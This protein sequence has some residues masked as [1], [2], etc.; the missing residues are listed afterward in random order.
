M[1]IPTKQDF[2]DMYELAEAIMETSFFSYD[3]LY[4]WERE[5]GDYMADH[6]GLTTESGCTKACFIPSDTTWVIKVDLP[7]NAK[8]QSGY[9]WQEAMNY[10]YAIQEGVEDAF[11]ACYFLDRIEGHDF[12]IEELVCVDES[13][14]DS[15]C[16]DY[17]SRIAESERDNGNEVDDD[18]IYYDLCDEERIMAIFGAM[19]IKH[20]LLDF[21]SKYQIND[22]HVGNFG[23]RGDFPVI[24]DY[25]GY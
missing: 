14:T 23:Y 3:S 22:L 16:Y 18:E 17:A 1:V 20:R 15:A 7:D 6:W 24:I 4:Q 21:I 9:C 11:A 10:Q 13:T 2:E 19:D 8:W 25:S 5:W 12:Y